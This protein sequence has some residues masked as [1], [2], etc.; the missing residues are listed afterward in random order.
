[1]HLNTPYEFAKEKE[2]H[3]FIFPYC[4]SS[5]LKMEAEYSSRILVTKYHNSEDHSMTPYPHVNLKA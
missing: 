2:K 1:M 3:I 4:D 5:N